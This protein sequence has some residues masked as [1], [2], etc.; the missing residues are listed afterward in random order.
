MILE[1]VEFAVGAGAFD[2]L[3]G[4]HARDLDRTRHKRRG[5]GGEFRY[6]G[7]VERSRG[8]S[9]AVAIRRRFG[10]RAPLK[11]CVSDHSPGDGVRR[12]PQRRRQTRRRRH[13]GRPLRP[14][15][16]RPRRRRVSLRRGVPGHRFDRPR[17]RAPA[18]RRPPGRRRRPRGRGRRRPLQP[19][20]VG[21]RRPDLA[22][23]RRGDARRVGRPRRRRRPSGPVRR[24]AGGGRSRGRT[25]PPARDRRGPRWTGPRR[26][27]DQDP[28]VL[29][30]LR[31]PAAADPTRGRVRPASA[32]PAAVAGDRRASEVDAPRPPRLAVLE[33]YPAAVFDRLDGGDRT[34]YKNH[35][36]RH[37]AARR[38]NVAAL[39]D[40][41]VRF[42]DDVARD[43]AVATD[44]ALD[45]VAAAFA[46]AENYADA[47]DP[48]SSE[49]DRKE[50]RIYA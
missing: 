41:G 38:R 32:A 20:R 9:D 21:A 8:P 35:Q 13:L 24:G 34:G 26:V 37:V 28:D 29:R 4:G 25:A 16:R 46:A 47:L 7:S 30:H 50:A 31:A 3:R 6:R 42:A 10:R 22:R 17:R 23:V 12:R 11:T 40:A 39:V 49:R 14:R 33:T 36:R 5:A 19:S 18:A 27:P 44:D 45:A 43:C 2:L 48:N 1:H 15:R